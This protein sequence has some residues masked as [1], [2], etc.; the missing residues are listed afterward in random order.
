MQY[1]ALADAADR[2]VAAQWKRTYRY[3]R[4]LLE[5]LRERNYYLL[6]VSHSPKT[7]LDK[8]CPRLGF[9]KVYG[10][11]YEIGDDHAFTGV[12]LVRHLIFNKRY[13]AQGGGEGKSYAHAFCRRR[14][15]GIGHTLS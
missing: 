1:G 6:A 13:P 7:V 5:D 9:D 4:L 10:T 15:Y 11:M 2:M 8:F 12:V 3:T 14:G